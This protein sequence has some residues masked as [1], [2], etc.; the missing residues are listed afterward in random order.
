MV[1]SNFYQ[2]TQVLHNADVLSDFLEKKHYEGVMFNV[3][4]VVRGWWGPISRKIA[5]RNT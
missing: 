3:I 4:S 2:A 1:T 5:F